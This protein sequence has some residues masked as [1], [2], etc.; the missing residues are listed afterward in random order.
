MINASLFGFVE[1]ISK[2]VEH[3]LTVT[4][5]VDVSVG[6]EVEETFKC[7]RINQV[8]IVRKAYTIRAVHVKWL[9]L[10]IGAA[11]GCWISEMA[12]PH[13]AWKILE[14]SSVMEDL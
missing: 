8:A 1:L 7:L 14:P 9:S 2:H 3:K 4:V 6:L 11:T 13:K 12:D 5:C 10:G